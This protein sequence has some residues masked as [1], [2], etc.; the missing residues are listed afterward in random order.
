MAC[1]VNRA[2]RPLTDDIR[3]LAKEAGF[4]ARGSLLVKEDSLLRIIQVDVLQ[5]VSSPGRIKFDLLFDLGV[6]GLSTFTPRSRKWVLRCYG[7]KLPDAE[8]KVDGDFVLTG[9][10]ADNSVRRSATSRTRHACDEFLM[11]FEDGIS[12]YRFV[13]DSALQF[14]VDGMELEDDF[15]RLQ[16][17]P[18]NALARLELAGVYA[19]FLG[20]EREANSIQE[21]AERFATGKN[22]DLDYLLP[23]IRE[24]ISAAG[25]TGVR[26]NV[27]T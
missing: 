21:A 3:R 14:L 22:K 12:L 15:K 13:R 17:H 5:N 25:A 23:R 11:R 20:L 10:P 27:K 4:A 8:G 26:S 7:S 1:A 24:N 19:S 2:I 9:G 16:L 6:P 18:W